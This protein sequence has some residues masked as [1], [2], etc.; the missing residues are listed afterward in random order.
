MEIWLD[1]ADFEL[2]EMAK[3][4]GVLHGITTNPSIAAKSKLN[5]EALLEKLLQIQN[6]PI[7][8]QVTTDEASKM[9]QQ[10]EALHKF[11]N[12]IIVKVPVT[13]AGL[14]AIH[15]L[16][17]MNI[18]TMATAIFDLNQV[19]L[20]SRAGA[21]YIAPYFSTI[22]EADMEGLEQFKAMNR[23]LE[24]YKLPAKLLA[25]SLKSS[26][27]VRQCVEFGAHAVTLN[28]E[29]FLSFIDTNPETVKRI[30]RFATDWKTAKAR[31]SLPL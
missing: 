3:Q 7:T 26:E 13:A 22:V 4:M 17:K 21:Q 19:L 16:S 5:L 2:I 30:D 15:A 20:A 25:A 23:L 29:V 9:V 6:G 27:H 24:R 31:N 12:R 10:G 1:T 28:K 18:S 11:S 8:A 14:K